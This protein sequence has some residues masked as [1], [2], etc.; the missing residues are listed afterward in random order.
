M[1]KLLFVLLLLSIFVFA[2][3]CDEN[4]SSIPNDNTD[5]TE[6]SD[7]DSSADGNTDTTDNT[8]IDNN[9]NNNN[10]TDN[11]NKAPAT[12]LITI[13]ENGNSDYTLV[14]DEAQGKRV[15]SIA[16]SL[17]NGIKNS[18]E[19]KLKSNRS[20]ETEKNKE[21]HLGLTKHNIS[22]ATYNTLDYDEYSIRVVGE[23][24][25]MWQRRNL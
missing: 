6:S 4:E 2:I 16:S 7:G 23:K 3:A 25:F 20:G 1:K 9:N 17:Y 15:I 8:D 18:T 22:V 24:I 19:V 12:H 11:D 5:Q 14:A 10:H 21:I 13:V